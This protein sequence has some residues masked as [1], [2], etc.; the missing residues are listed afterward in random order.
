MPCSKRMLSVSKSLLIFIIKTTLIPD[1][2]SY[3]EILCRARNGVGL[4]LL[5]LTSSSGIN[6]RRPSFTGKPLP[7]SLDD[8]SAPYSTMTSSSMLLTNLQNSFSTSSVGTIW[9]KKKKKVRV[10]ADKIQPKGYH[11][12]NPLLWI[13]HV[14]PNTKDTPPHPSTPQ[15]H[16]VW[17]VFLSSS[18]NEIERECHIMR[19]EMNK[20]DEVT[21]SAAKKTLILDGQKGRRQPAESKQQTE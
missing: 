21:R 13:P 1:L 12:S 15:C 4:H 3:C 6:F 14:S 5:F 8:I 18:C 20:K 2:Y 16:T 9:M 7:K 19:D 11:L 17:L 10:C